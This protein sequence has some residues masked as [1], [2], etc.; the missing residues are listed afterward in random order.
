MNETVDTRPKVDMTN[1]KRVWFDKRGSG[2]LI[3]MLFEKDG[4]QGTIR[5]GAFKTKEEAQAILL[6]LK[7]SSTCLQGE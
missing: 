3:R 1:L 5:L 6:A 7:R 2:W 4:E